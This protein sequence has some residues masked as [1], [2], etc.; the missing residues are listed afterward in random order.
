[1]TREQSIRQ[2]SATKELNEL[3]ATP[4]IVMEHGLRSF[5][6][7]DGSIVRAVDDISLC[8]Q[9]GE[10]V[11]LLG[12]SG[13]GKSTLLRVV[14]GL[15]SLDS[16]RLSINGTLVA[17]PVSGIAVGPQARNLSMMFQSYAL[18]PHMS[19]IENVRY[20]LRVRNGSHRQTRADQARQAR[21]ALE[22]AGVADLT[23]QY[24]N[25]ISGGQQQRVALARNLVAGE[26][27]MLFDEPLSNVDAKVRVQLRSQLADLHRNLSFTALY[28][29][30]DQAEAMFLADMIA[31][32]DSGQILQYAT[33]ECVY[34]QP[35]TLGVARFI[36]GLNEFPAH[37]R[38]Q[39]TTISADCAFGHFDFEATR[40]DER[41]DLEK[42]TI[43]IRP[44]DIKL[45]PCLTEA[46]VLGI[47]LETA[48]LGSSRSYRIQ[49]GSVV[50]EARSPRDSGF[51]V[52]DSIAVSVGPKSV[53]LFD[54]DG[55]LVPAA[56]KE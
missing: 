25:A 11:V 15:E 39:A 3:T 6:R 54:Q 22:S 47:V 5:K 34:E 56:C 9:Q 21:A 52:G 2:G 10:F 7:R 28:V 31:V 36:G 13:C 37:A 20:P 24:P 23:D 12:P 40:G 46:P 18:W 27:L 26:G 1:M 53:L 19:V 30:H 41:L 45:S 49:V 50:V 55:T 14:A 48:F 44:E 32:M 51:Q 17:D 16:G 43:G 4:A 38:R 29:T 33:P 8:V 35:A 42:L